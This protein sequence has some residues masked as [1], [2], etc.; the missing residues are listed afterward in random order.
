MT[1]SVSRC[2]DRMNRLGIRAWTPHDL[3]RTGRT[4][5][6]KLGIQS[7]IAERLVNHAVPG[8]EGV[9]N[10]HDYAAEKRLAWEKWAEFVGFLASK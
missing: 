2:L 7:H 8:M 9:Y 3:R 10:V 6:A 1:R 4:G 5:L